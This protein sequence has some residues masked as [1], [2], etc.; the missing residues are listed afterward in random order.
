MLNLVLSD[1]E[2]G[3]LR[4]RLI[5]GLPFST[6]AKNRKLSIMQM[7]NCICLVRRKIEKQQ[8]KNKAEAMAKT[9]LKFLTA[10]PQEKA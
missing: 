9:L 6:I 10:G 5:S 8:T 2:M 7:R 4:D 1:V 3:V